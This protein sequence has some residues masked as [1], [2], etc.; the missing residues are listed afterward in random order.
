MDPIIVSE[1]AISL[2]RAYMILTQQA[3]WSQDQIETE[4]TKT[5]SKFMAESSMPI[6]PVKP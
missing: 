5:Y 2:L 3:G 6:D 1:I 4:F